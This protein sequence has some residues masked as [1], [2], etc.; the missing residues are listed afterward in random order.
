[1]IEVEGSKESVEKLEIVMEEGVIRGMKMAMGGK[2]EV[3][4]VSVKYDCRLFSIPAYFC[5]L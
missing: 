3:T 2:V 1:M 5:F 4:R